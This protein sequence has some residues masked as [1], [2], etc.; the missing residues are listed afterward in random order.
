MELKIN[1]KDEQKE[2]LDQVVSDFSLEGNEETIKLLVNDI[3][4]NYQ[5]QNVFGEIRCVGGCFS[6]D[7]Y[8]KMEFDGELISKMKDIFKQY[9]FEEYESEEEEIGKVIRS[10]I[11]FV[12]QECDLEKVFKK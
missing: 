9:D 8:I 1:L 3:L 4:A 10:I 7:Q 6:N 12:D 11:N 2:F 5:Y